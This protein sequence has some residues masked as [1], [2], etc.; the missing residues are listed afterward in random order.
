MSL[1]AVVGA[2]PAGTATDAAMDEYQQKAGH[3]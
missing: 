1:H 2:G 3:S